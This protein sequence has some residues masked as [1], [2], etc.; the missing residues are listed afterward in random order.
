MKIKKFLSELC[1][2]SR[3]ESGI[4]L[5]MVMGVITLLIVLLA[6]FTFDV[7]INK[8]K[9][10]NQQDRSQARLNAESGLQF[11]L[12]KLK[13]Y[14]EG[15][16]L[17]EKQ[18]QLKS[19]FPPSDLESLIIQP[20]IYPIAQPKNASA[21]QKSALDEFNKNIIFRG[22]LSVTITK[23]SGFL[24]P[25]ALRIKKNTSPTRNQNDDQADMSDENPD[26][27][28]P[29]DDEDN[30]KKITI[31]AAIEKKLVETLERLLKDKFDNDDEFHSK[32]A[33]VDAKLLIKEIK[34]YVNNRNDF[35]DSEKPDIENKFSQKKITPKH[36]PMS[37]IDELYLLPSW[38]DALVEL[39]KD[40][41]SVHEV[42]M[43][44]INDITI[45]DL[46]IL[47]PNINNVQIEEFFKYRD[48]DED[49]NI[50]GKKFKDEADFKNVVTGTLNIVNGPEYDTRI[51]ELKQAGLQINTAGKIY[52][53]NSRGVYNNATY[54]LVAYVDLP[55][56]EV[57]KQKGNQNSNNQDTSNP[58]PADDPESAEIPP[59]K[60]DNSNQ[61][62][63]TPI[64]LL[65]PRVIEI[66]I[67]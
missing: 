66:R 19:S 1:F 63:P 25:N 52:K 35:K 38:D 65:S 42:T 53:I 13:L 54:N 24:N 55:I 51:N 33:N 11:A 10:Y 5:I 8:L 2:I 31:D 18:E 64:E 41:L 39:I 21:I 30:K 27:I 9:V 7:K 6:T 15:R 36:A 22:E 49:K 50:K 61:E 29:E 46:K 67:E 26:S 48:G 20:F 62:K 28:S 12:A 47:F 4:A 37:S 59:E 57:K 32:Y 58:P 17:L 3:S 23:L 16:N 60:P 56:K 43:I 40:R 34:F 44:S 14:Q 45:E